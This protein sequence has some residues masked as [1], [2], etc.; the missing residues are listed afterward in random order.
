M[1]GH[2]VHT[3]HA[4]HPLIAVAAQ[5]LAFAPHDSADA[6]LARLAHGLGKLA[7]PET[8]ALGAHFLGLPSPA[9]RGG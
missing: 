1:S 5:A 4:F 8:V 6:K 2:A 7:S 9:A 3:G